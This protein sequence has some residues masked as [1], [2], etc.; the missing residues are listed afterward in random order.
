MNHSHSHNMP[1]PECNSPIPMSMDR[2]LSGQPIKC[3]N[4]ACGLELKIDTQ[5]SQKA[6]EQVSK[7][8]KEVDN[9][10]KKKK[11]LR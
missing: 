4:P 7:L 10:E 3:L 6:L 8:K 9:F 5:K 2:L 1:C 11:H